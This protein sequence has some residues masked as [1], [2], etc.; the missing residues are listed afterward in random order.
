[1]PR[2]GIRQSVGAQ[3]QRVAKAGSGRHDLDLERGGG[4]EN[5]IRCGMGRLDGLNIEG[6]CTSTGLGVGGGG[7]W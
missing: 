4:G 1:M 6:W 7:A 3:R 2:E 5:S